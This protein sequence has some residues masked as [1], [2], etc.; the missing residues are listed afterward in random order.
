MRA[1]DRMTEAEELTIQRYQAIERGWNKGIPRF[2]MIYGYLLDHV[3][4]R[5]F[6]M[7]HR[8]KERAIPPPPD[9]IAAFAA[10]F[11]AIKP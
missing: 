2:E 8:Y 10:A 3:H 7:M 11:A 1:R 4:N 9:T 5:H 6:R